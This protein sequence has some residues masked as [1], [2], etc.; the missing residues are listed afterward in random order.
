MYNNPSDSPPRF[1]QRAYAHNYR[2]P[3]IYH[4]ILTKLDG[5]EPFGEVGGDARIPPGRAGCAYIK[6]SGLGHIIAKS[7][8]NIQKL[9]PIIKMYQFMVMPDHVHILLRVL[10]WSDEHLDFYIKSLKDSVAVEYSKLLCREITSDC[11]FEES[12]C[13]KP[14]LLKRSLN[15]LYIYI[16]ENPHRFAMRL[17][18]PNFFK[19]L[20]NLVIC[21]N[22]Y[23]AF[24]NLFFL[25]N[26]DKEVV[27]ISRYI[28]E[29]EKQIKRE[30][31]IEKAKRGTVLV[32]PFISKD[33]KDVRKEA[34][35]YG[36][37]V[38]LITHEKFTERYKPASHDF[39]LCCGGRLLIISMGCPPKTVLTREI[40]VRMNELAQKIGFALV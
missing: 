4:I 30:A 20:R 16:K 7:I 10:A 33:E 17:Q 12:Y 38:I 32:S 34:E 6:E 21:G 8:L 19:R 25:R 18:F 23:E 24:G 29:K 2:A 14:L 26:P 22:Q 27:K 13:D 9:Y 31:F 35:T 40:C 3:F 37:S 28:S 15:G 5:V 11:I 1:H 39:N 36:A